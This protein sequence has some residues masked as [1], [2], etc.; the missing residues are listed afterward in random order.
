[1]TH[2]PQRPRPPPS[3]KTTIHT[4]PE[5]RQPR[6]PRASDLN[7]PRTPRRHS[8]P[9]ST[10]DHTI[11]PSPTPTNAARSA[12]ERPSRSVNLAHPL[13][14]HRTI[15]PAAQRHST[16]QLATRDPP[17]PH[18]LHVSPTSPS[19]APA[20]HLSHAEAATASPP[21]PHP[22]AMLFRPQPSAG[23]RVND[24]GAGGRSDTEPMGS[25]TRSAPPQ[26]ILA[27]PR[28][29]QRPPEQAYS[30]H[31]VMIPAHK[32][33]TAAARS[34]PQWIEETACYDLPSAN[35]QSAPCS[36]GRPSP[37]GQTVPAHPKRTATPER[38]DAWNSLLKARVSARA[39]NDRVCRVQQE[40]TISRRKKAHTSAKVAHVV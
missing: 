27:D 23:G 33:E 4:P 11:H 2:G 35:A 15:R 18:L 1:M 9:A 6:H 34:D 12:A 24:A 32:R 16:Q 39:S 25:A 30:A 36:V 29:T 5:M 10:P 37:T 40:K 17:A 31:H 22:P 28:R 8:P 14:D 20:A 3:H 13:D 7:I 38:N 19:D 26:P 21:Q